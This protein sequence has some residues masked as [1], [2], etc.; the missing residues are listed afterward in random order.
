[1]EGVQGV[2]PSLGRGCV[3]DSMP[4]AQHTG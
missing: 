1:V 2:L 4:E 3:Q